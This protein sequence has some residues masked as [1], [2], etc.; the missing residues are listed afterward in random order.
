MSVMKTVS[1]RI[2][3]R[4]P[5]T[6]AAVA[7]LD[8]VLLVGR[9]SGSLYVVLAIATFVLVFGVPAYVLL[10]ACVVGLGLVTLVNVVSS[11]DSWAPVSQVVLP[12]LLVAGMITAA[13]RAPGSSETPGPNRASQDTDSREVEIA[14]QRPSSGPT[15]GDEPRENAA[16]PRSTTGTG[17]PS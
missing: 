9:P 14:T 16:Q 4:S 11:G 13:E 5:V 8:L 7:V 1:E 2:W 17:W 6:L 3:T 15:L 12:L 10:L